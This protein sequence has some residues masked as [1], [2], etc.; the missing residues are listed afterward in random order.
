MVW[1]LTKTQ[2]INDLEHKFSRINQQYDREIT[3]ER[4]RKKKNDP[5]T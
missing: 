1:Q 5:M 3:K 4:S 2:Q